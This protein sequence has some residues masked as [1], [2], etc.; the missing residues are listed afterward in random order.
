MFQFYLSSIKSRVHTPEGIV[1]E[2]FQFYLSSIK[3]VIHDP[4]CPCNK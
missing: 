2:P 4:D 3:R 1:A